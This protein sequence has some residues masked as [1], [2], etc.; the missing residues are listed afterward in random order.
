MVENMRAAAK[1]RG[2]RNPKS[3]APNPKEAPTSTKLQER[4]STT[5]LGFEIWSFFGAW[6]LGFE[7]SR[8][9]TE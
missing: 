6:S 2:R 4:L 1:T 5:I 7:A 3:Q 8:A 9:V